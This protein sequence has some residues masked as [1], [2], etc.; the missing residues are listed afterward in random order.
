MPRCST[1]ALLAVSVAGVVRPACGIRC[2]GAN[3]AAMQRARGA[4]A[5]CTAGAD[6]FDLFRYDNRREPCFEECGGVTWFEGHSTGG[7][8]FANPTGKRLCPGVVDKDECVTPPAGS[9]PR[10]APHPPPAQ[11]SRADTPALTRAR[12]AGVIAQVQL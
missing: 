6:R 1:A 10:S 7:K 8:H 9:A 4:A 12:P 2:W 5:S 11:G 3:A